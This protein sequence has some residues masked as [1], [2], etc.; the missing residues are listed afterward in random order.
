LEEANLAWVEHQA[1]AEHHTALARMYAERIIRIEEEIKNNA[2]QPRSVVMRQSPEET[3]EEIERS[4][5]ES[6]VVYPARAVR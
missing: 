5:P 2:H 3:R 6:I 1:A 4:R